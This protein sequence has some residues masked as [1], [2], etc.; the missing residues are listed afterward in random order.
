MAEAPLN[1]NVKATFT[2]KKA[3]KEAETATQKLTKSTKKLA[4]TLGFA[5]STAA[6]LSYSKASVKAFV[7]DDNAARSLGMTL[8]NLGLEYGGTSQSVN[9]FISDLEKST[10]VLDDE[11]RPAMDRLLRA[12]GSVTDSQK[13]LNLALDI[14][15]GTGKSLTS[16]SQGLQKAYL[17][18]NASLGR[19][20]VGL[21]KAELTS[22]SFEEVQ[23][24]LTELFA[25]Q[26]SSA[27]ESYAGELA[28]LT[29]AGNNAKEIIG[30]GIV[31]ALTESGGAFN[32]SSDEI[33]RYATNISNLVLEMGRF[34]RLASSLPSFFDMVKNPMGAFDNYWKVADEIDAQ[35]K[36]YN[37][38][39]LFEGKGA[40]YQDTISP[41]S[42]LAAAE[43]RKKQAD[44]LAKNNIDNAKKINKLTS[45]SLKLAK[46]KANFDLQKI[47]I[48]AALK[49]KISDEE[50]ARLLLMKAIDNEN[51]ADIDKYTKALEAAQE[52]TK[53]L[54]E[55]LNTVKSVKLADPFAAFKIGTQEA[56]NKVL[57]LEKTALLSWKTM[58]GLTYNPGQNAD[59]NY[60]ARIT[61]ITNYITSGGATNANNGT[62]G[63]NGATGTVTVNVAGTVVSDTDLTTKIVDTINQTGWAGIQTAWNRAAKEA[64]V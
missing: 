31:E 59:R 52:K 9:N 63:T 50:K 2:G 15:A 16:V 21:S 64:T 61:Y 10:G 27:A 14:S 23:T 45:E 60:D 56:I 58:A 11:L 53:A 12:T 20:G 32:D 42:A 3:F 6:I 37:R 7:A 36:A 5:F 54:A 13:L 22:S 47:A 46:A 4:G 48:E 49:G 34:G 26:A 24:R 38:K 51:A 30:R 43:A 17:G 19:L 44:K 62:N 41:S 1:I 35:R 33:E 29:V 55:S 8:K 39:Q 57:E 28:K 40:G 18:N 25:G